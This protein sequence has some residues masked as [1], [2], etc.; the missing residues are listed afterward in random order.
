MWRAAIHN[1]VLA[2]FFQGSY[3]AKIDACIKSTKITTT[4]YL[5]EELE[6]SFSNNPFFQ[7]WIALMTTGNS[8]GLEFKEK[9]QCPSAIKNLHNNKNCH[10]IASAYYCGSQL[11]IDSNINPTT[12]NIIQNNAFGIE[13]VD[14]SNGEYPSFVNK[15]THLQSIPLQSRG[16]KD[17]SILEKYFL[18][19]DKIV[20]YDK[21][22]NTTSFEF[23]HYITSKLQINSS[24]T[25]F[26]SRKS[27]ANIVPTTK[28]RSDLQTARPDLNIDVF[29]A[30][31]TFIKDH[32]DRYIFLGERIHMVFPAGLDCFGKICPT[33][34]QR[35][36]KYTQINIYETT[37]NNQMKI[38]SSD[39]ANEVTVNYYL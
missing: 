5:F 25:I 28:I 17:F 15:A 1:D 9:N 34:G 11:L 12:S 4:P 24:L 16:T 22:I 39:G 10:H 32:H 23:I 27:G 19:E 26:T 36:N 35:I 21:Y 14:L 38:C 3:N 2:K 6:R 7:Q 31:Q 8:I 33:S 29:F 30:D 37:S 13:E 20:I 18:P